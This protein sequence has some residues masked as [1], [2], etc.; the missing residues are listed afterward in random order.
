MDLLLSGSQLGD[1]D[2][3]AVYANPNSALQTQTAAINFSL[4]ASL[5]GDETYSDNPQRGLDVSVGTNGEIS[6]RG[7]GQSGDSLTDIQQAK[8]AARAQSPLGQAFNSIPPLVWVGLIALLL[9]R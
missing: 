9:L 8:A 4:P 5:F 1:S 6:V 3:T 7:R 2:N